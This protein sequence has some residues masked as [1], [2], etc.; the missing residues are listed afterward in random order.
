VPAI[1]EIEPENE[2]SPLRAFA[3][4]PSE[5]VLILG[6]RRIP[7]VE[8]PT[9]NSN[10]AI[11]IC[12]SVGF[13]F[14]Q[15]KE[16]ISAAVELKPDIC[17]APA[18]IMH[19]HIPSIKRAEKMA[20]R[21][22][23]W[24]RD[25]L[26]QKES[27]VEDGTDITV[28]A[29]ILPISAEQQTWY[30]NQLVDD[31]FRHLISGLVVYDA[32]SLDLIDKSITTL[33][34]LAL[35]EPANPRQLLREISLGVDLFVMPFIN[36]A[37]DAGVAFDFS[38]PAP[39]MGESSSAQHSLG[40][41]A[42]DPAFATDLEP[43]QS[44]CQCYTCQRHHRA[45]LQHLLSAREML[46]WVLLQIHNHHVIDQFFAGVR[47]S[48]AKGSFEQDKDAFERYYESELPVKYND[49]PR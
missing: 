16:Y 10:T 6:P 7:P 19:D 15:V 40:V 33:P 1:Y 30:T 22:A 3:S 18:D 8:T 17:V 39:T 37:T 4:H 2:E 29:P 27:C 44:G 23:V 28:F 5:T 31:E 35:T 32:H 25:I 11:S 46:A 48:I 24:L 43:L 49:G 45:F 9:S 34:I 26:A 14:L 13:R 47:A 42:W 12:T 41:D 21:T 20:D 36:T 38:F